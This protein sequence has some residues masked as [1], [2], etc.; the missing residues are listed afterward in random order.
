[1][2]NT[3]VLSQVSLLSGVQARRHGDWLGATLQVDV[4]EGSRDRTGLRGA[5]SGTSASFVA[6]G[7]LG[8]GRRG[9]WLVSL[10]RSYLDWLIRKVEPDFDSTLGFYDGYAKIV[11]SPRCRGGMPARAPS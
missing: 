7:P 8:S 6:E 2:L 10:R 1:M 3:D 11:A 4:R 5:V 9:S